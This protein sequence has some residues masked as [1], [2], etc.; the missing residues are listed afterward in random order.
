MG[1]YKKAQEEEGGTFSTMKTVVLVLIV[2]LILL[3]FLATVIWPIIR[4]TPWLK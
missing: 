4:E 1:L 3:I 2:L